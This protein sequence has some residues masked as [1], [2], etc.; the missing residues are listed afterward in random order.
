MT[1]SVMTT[2]SQRARGTGLRVEHDHRAL[3]RTGHRD[4]LEGGG[5]ADKTVSLACS[6]RERHDLRSSAPGQPSRVRGRGGNRRDLRLRSGAA[7]GTPRSRSVI[8]LT[9]M[10]RERGWTLSAH[11]PA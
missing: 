5:G 2:P 10:R 3:T 4:E 1:R 9:V 7:R 8:E 11:G 6:P